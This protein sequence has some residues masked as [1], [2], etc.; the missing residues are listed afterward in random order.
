[1]RLVFSI[2]ALLLFLSVISARPFPYRNSPIRRV[3]NAERLKRGLG[4]MPPMFKRVLPGGQLPTRTTAAKR[5][6]PSP[7]SR[8]VVYTGRIEVR[9][10]DGSSYG[11]VINAQYGINGVNFGG[12]I[13]A[14]NVQF[15]TDSSGTG[16]FNIFATNPNFPAPHFVGATTHDFATLGSNSGTGVSLG[17]IRQTPPNSHLSG[18]ESAIWSID[19]TT[20]EI[21]AHWVN[22]DGSKIPTF[23][24]VDIRNNAV[25]FTGNIAL[26]NQQHTWPISEVKFF[27]ANI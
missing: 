16:P 19:P 18:G 21:K 2:A 25:V 17:N 9:T 20:K 5:A 23:I 10:L 4:P 6:A 11:D 27:L 15:T 22:P 26:Y 8:S 7:S 3:T 13:P 24:G 1:M 14:L 12:P